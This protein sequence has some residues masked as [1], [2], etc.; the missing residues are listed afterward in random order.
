MFLRQIS[1]YSL[2]SVCVPDLVSMSPFVICIISVPSQSVQHDFHLWALSP[3]VLFRQTCTPAAK[4]ACVLQ[5]LQ[6]LGRRICLW[7]CWTRKLSRQEAVPV[8]PAAKQC[9]CHSVCFSF[10]TQALWLPSQNWSL[11]PGSLHLLP[12]WLCHS[13]DERRGCHWSVSITGSSM[14]IQVWG[15]ARTFGKVM[16]LTKL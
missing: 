4:W 11:L 5:V 8:P 9:I 1:N 3:K 13:S 16:F 2:P 6:C 12:H 10:S 15:P 14:G 7:G